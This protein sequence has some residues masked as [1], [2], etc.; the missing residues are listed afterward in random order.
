[1]LAEIYKDRKP[2]LDDIE[3]VKVESY[4]VALNITDDPDPQTEY[5]A[6]FSLQFCSALALLTGSAGLADFNESV[7]WD[8]NI[9]SLTKK[10]KVATAPAIDASYPKQWGAA[11]E[12]TFKN[13]ETVRKG[14]DFPKGD[15]ENAVTADDLREKFIGMTF[16]YP[17]EKRNELADRILQ[18]E[19]VPEIG[20][21]MAEL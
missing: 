10:V 17:M 14:T 3:S 11:V 1:L 7:L 12:V 5:A 6:K 20:Q 2:S 18:L 19:T 16:K 9:R 15:P 4:Q 13:G 8:E 21:V